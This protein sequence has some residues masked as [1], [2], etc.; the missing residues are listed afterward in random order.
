M[1]EFIVYLIF[2]RDIHRKKYS[3]DQTGR[4]RKK[5][6]LSLKKVFGESAPFEVFVN[7]SVRFFRDFCR[8]DNEKSICGQLMSA[9]AMICA[10]SPTFFI[11]ETC[12]IENFTPNSSS[13]AA[14]S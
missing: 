12:F 11:D 7:L 3:A 10:I 6:A 9:S 2:F 1:T 14:M 4:R 8:A 13:T 5:G